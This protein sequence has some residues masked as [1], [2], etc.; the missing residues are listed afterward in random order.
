MIKLGVIRKTRITGP[1]ALRFDEDTLADIGRVTAASVL[2]NIR[3]QKQAD[4][5]GLKMNAPATREAKRR[6]G[7]PALSLVFKNHRFVRG[8]GVSWAWLVNLTGNLVSIKPSNAELANI[9][10]ALQQRGYQG[11]FAVSEKARQAIRARVRKFIT[12]AVKKATDKVKT[13][14]T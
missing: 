9:S 4:G 2:D 12:E 10:R 3:S 13:E 14:R 8:N 11:W 6:A 1:I 5:S 7:L